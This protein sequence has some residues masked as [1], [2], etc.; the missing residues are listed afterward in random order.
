LRTYN[1]WH[2][3]RCNEQRCGADR[4]EAERC[5]SKD[6]CTGI[7]GEMAG[8]SQGLEPESAPRNALSCLLLCVRGS[9]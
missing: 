8:E 3:E 6:Y 7:V 9:W 1:A 2:R 5:H 4:V